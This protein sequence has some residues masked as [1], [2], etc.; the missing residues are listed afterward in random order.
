MSLAQLYPSRHDRERAILLG[1]IPEAYGPVFAGRLM[2]HCAGD[3]LPAR[4]GE[5]KE[6]SV[7][8][9]RVL[10]QANCRAEHAEAVAEYLQVIPGLYAMAKPQSMARGQARVDFSIVVR[11]EL[12]EGGLAR[13]AEERV[14]QY[15]WQRADLQPIDVVALRAERLPEGEEAH[16]PPE[17]IPPRRSL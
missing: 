1:D 13:T 4:S 7:T 3:D 16:L 8:A 9:Y 10:M 17:H 12:Q 6:R 15:L 11:E 5:G 2:M 14:S